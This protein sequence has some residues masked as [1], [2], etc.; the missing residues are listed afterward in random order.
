[1][2]HQTF[3]RSALAALA[4]GAGTVSAQA[5]EI[6]RAITFTPAQVSFAQNFQKYV[7]LVNERGAGVVQ[8]QTIGGPETIPQARM[9]EA[10]QNG[11]ADMFLLPAGLYLNI[12]PEGEAFAGSNRNPMDVRA[13]GGIE[14]IN[15][16][17]H[18]KGNAHVLAHV[19]GGAGFHLWLTEKPEIT[20]SGE[21]DLT[22]IRLRSSPLYRAFLEELNATIVV[23]PAAEVYTSLE[24][25]VVDG[26][27]YP[28]TGLRDYGW[29]KFLKYR[30]DP[31]FFQTDVLIS[32]NLDAWN[33]LSD[34]A[35][36]ILQQAAI[37]HEQSSYEAN[38]ALN[39]SEKAAMAAE[40]IETI[41][42]TGAQAETFLTTAYDIAWARL[43]ERDATHHDALKDVF[44]EPIE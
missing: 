2:L 6:V 24:R 3:I 5:T 29:N 28:V 12:V 1:M 20:D 7:D 4:I 19:D 33:E 32:M 9:G 14:M 26:A 17:F 10:Q 40:G 31:S 18:E 15:E 16:I 23:Q 44:F 25:G 22:G 37:E 34:E 43:K 39:E 41:E 36:E 8:I 27:G 38:L 21:V 11:I 35:R 42:L 30:L 13:D